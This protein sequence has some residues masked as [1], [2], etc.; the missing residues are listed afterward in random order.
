M[1]VWDNPIMELLPRNYNENNEVQK[2]LEIFAD[3]LYKLA[4]VGT[5]IVNEILKNKT[6]EN[7]DISIIMLLRNHIEIIDG[8]AELT[9]VSSINNVE[10]LNRILFESFLY[11]KYILEKD[12]ERRGKSYYY[13]Y[14]LDVLKWLNRVKNNT[15]ENI[16]L[17]GL[18][19][20]DVV[21]SNYTLPSFKSIDS[22]ITTAKVNI[23]K[24]IFS[25]VKTEYESQS[26][27]HRG[28]WYSLFGGPS[29]IKE[30][31][32]NL[33]MPAL[34]EIIYRY[35]S[36]KMHSSDAVKDI[37]YSDNGALISQL[38]Q[39]GGANTT[40]M[41]CFFYTISIYRQ[42]VKCFSIEDKV[43]E[44]YYSSI[45]K[46]YLEDLPNMII[47]SSKGSECGSS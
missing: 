28:Q 9:K 30:L 6:L 29:N 3:S 47:F 13:Y 7:H 10:R 19:K 23:D 46:Y 38:R 11:I 35:G 14:L 5:H 22:E 17:Q 37:S 25:E 4:N 2:R 42:I 20:Q 33:K 40:T 16:Y 1:G 26:K 36:K 15:T 34:Y 45:K 21:L 24:P 8:I 12:T 44:S 43:I 31:A 32:E 41:Y 18:I 27:K 39:P